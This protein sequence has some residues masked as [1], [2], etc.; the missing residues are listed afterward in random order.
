MKIKLWGVRGSIATTGPDTEFYGGNTSCVTIAHDD[1]V[2]VLDG[3]TGIR[4]LSGSN[5]PVYKRIDVLLSHLHLDHIQGLG[6]FSPL[7]DS[8]KEIHIWGPASSSQSLFARLSRYLSPPLFP[9]L[10][11]DLPCKLHLHEIGNS[12]FETGPFRVQSNYIIHPGPTV[13]FRVANHHAVFTFMPDHE[14]AL[15]NK[16]II[17]EARWISGYDLAEGADLLLHDAQ[18]TPDEYNH[19]RG[20]GHSTI[21]DACLFGSLT[22]VQRILLG[23]HD[24]SHTDTFLDDMFA[25]F[26]KNAGTIPPAS[27]AKEGAEIDL[28]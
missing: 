13:G 17:K 2:L 26:K 23:H 22:S 18:F 10:L 3:G 4:Q 25:T 20:W 6:F 12:Q 16:G 8:S 5:Y 28:T 7:F 19:K 11:R 24:P 1:Y 15:G 9:V 27:L 14:P 21:D